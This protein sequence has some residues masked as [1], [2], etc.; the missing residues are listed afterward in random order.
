M[1][2]VLFFAVLINF[3]CGDKYNDVTVK[4]I[5]EERAIYLKENRANEVY[6]LDDQKW[7]IGG[8]RI[9][10][11]TL[12]SDQYNT[13]EFQ[14][15]RDVYFELKYPKQNNF[16]ITHVSA[17]VDQGPSNLGKAYIVDGGIGEI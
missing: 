10:G 17:L 13:F 3:S 8:E 16:Y 11:D 6:N 15:V 4:I 7:Y 1:L 12:R 14:E 2:K 5:D 9:R